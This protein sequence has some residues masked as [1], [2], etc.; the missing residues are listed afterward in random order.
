MHLHTCSRYREQ[1][2]YSCGRCSPIW[3][4]RQDAIICPQRPRTA[5]LAQSKRTHRLY[6]PAREVQTVVSRA[7]KGCTASEHTERLAKAKEKAEGPFRE[8]QSQ[9]SEAAK[10]ARPTDRILDLA[11]PKK[12]AEGYQPC[13][14]VEW[15]VS[16]GAKN[17]V[18]SNRMSEMA[19]PIIRE[20][21]D[22][23]Q[24]NPDAFKVS[25]A[26]RKATA[27]ARIKELA[28]PIRRGT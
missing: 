28:Q 16:N 9:V 6:I 18:A 13:R 25:E 7:A 22:H 23:V 26:A 5:S 10:R 17:A 2:V 20:T 11:R 14:D 12:V 8:P 3:R 21:M 1:F 15:K 27:S 19:G 24:F 4:V